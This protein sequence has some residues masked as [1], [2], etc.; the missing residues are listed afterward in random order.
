MAFQWF[1]KL[2]QYGLP[3]GGT[4]PENILDFMLWRQQAERLGITLT[5][6][7]VR[8]AVNRMVG[9][10][11]FGGKPFTSSLLAQALVRSDTKSN[12]RSTPQDLLTAVTDELL[13]LMAQEAILGPAPQVAGLGSAGPDAPPIPVVTPGEFLKYYREQRT[14]LNV[15]MLPVKVEA[16]VA[17]AKEKKTP[18]SDEV[19]KKLFDDYKNAVPDPTRALPAFKEPERVKVEWVRV[20]PE[21]PYFKEA[22]QRKIELPPY[23]ATLGLAM[24][25]FAGLNAPG[26]ACPWTAL[27]GRR[28]PSIGHCRG[29]WN[30]RRT[31][32]SPFSRRLAPANHTHTTA[33]LHIRRRSTLSWGR[34]PLV[35]IVPPAPAPCRL[36]RR[37]GPVPREPPKSRNGDAC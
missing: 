7:D 27:A 32:V 30:M 17:S 35:P 10:D 13:V 15:W 8:A 24:S 28:S 11:V 3:P 6:T 23:L 34:W 21:L 4:R 1:S 18:P 37:P 16:F 29:I 14:T 22:A 33:T 5:E 31:R 9:A 26:A 12:Q 36:S 20:T 25:G 19:L 2:R